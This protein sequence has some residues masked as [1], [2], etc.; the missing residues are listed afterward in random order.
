MKHF[1]S[2]KKSQGFTLIELLTV[3]SI[4]G[5]IT[6]LF[7]VS[8][9]NVSQRSRDSQRKSNIKQIQAALELYRADTDTY[10]TNATLGSYLCGSSLV[11]GTTVYMQKIPCDPKSNTRYY[12]NGTSP[13][14]Y[15]LGSCIENTSDKD[16]VSSPPAG[17]SNCSPAYYYVATN[18]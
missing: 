7:T 15:V 9:V 13:S 8:Y 16:A 4:I 11:S 17:M 6:A 3:I 2:S 10:P 1:F 5:V 12:Y 18:P 14:T